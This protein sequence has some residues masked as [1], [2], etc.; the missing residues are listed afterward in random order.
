VFNL[1]VDAE[2]VYYVST[3]GVLVHNAYPRGGTGVTNPGLVIGRNRGA[4]RGMNLTGE[5]HSGL[6]RVSA[7]WR[8]LYGPGVMRR[9]HL[10]PLEMTRNRT[11]MNRMNVLGYTDEEAITF[12]NRQ[13]ADIPKVQHIQIHA[14]GWNPIWREWLRRNPTFAVSDIRAQVQSMIREFEL[15]RSSLGGRQYGR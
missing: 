6:N 15:P 3:A 2:H 13:I 8:G 12:V 10:V 4:F 1:E 9:H 5:T 7:E 11:F 14:E